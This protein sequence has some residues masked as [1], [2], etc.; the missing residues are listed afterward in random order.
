MFQAIK[1]HGHDVHAAVDPLAERLHMLSE[2]EVPVTPLLFKRRIDLRAIGAIQRLVKDFSPDIIHTF[3]KRSL[4]NV[5]IAT[6]GTHVPIIGYRGVRGNIHRLSP[7]SRLTF[8]NERLLKIICV[9]KA[10]EKSLHIAGI[11]EKKTV[12]IYKGHD[13][14]WYQPADR[15]A[16]TEW[17]I[18]QRAFV[19]GCAAKMR[20]RK[21]IGVLIRAIEQMN[22][23]NVHLIL[24]G[25]IADTKLSRLIK[26]ISMT[27]HIHPIGF[28]KDACAL[29][30]ACDV[31][32]MPSL[33]REGLPRAAIEAMAQ[34]TPA[35]VTDVG[36]MPE[37]VR[38]GQEGLV[39][40]PGNVQALT[41]AIRTLVDSNPKRLALANAARQRIIDSFDIKSTVKQTL[42]VYDSVTS[43]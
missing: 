17:N 27:K 9:C 13:V 25:E 43:K 41:N 24:A 10:V 3:N 35:I 5:L 16:F 4:T 12:T 7:E 20:P 2:A 30:G 19:I 26:S 31:F 37:L 8:F 32:V 42:A 29:M 34:R 38:H 40:P 11:S 33:R 22:N 21:G 39:I 28:R 1:E 14:D 36:G 15:S 23:P 18:P 6:A